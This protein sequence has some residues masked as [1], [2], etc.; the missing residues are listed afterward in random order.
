MKKI[1]FIYGVISGTFIIGSMIIGFIMSDGEGFGSSQILGFSIMIVALSFIFMGIKK[2]RDE[3][4]GGVIK[5]WPAFGLGLAISAVATVM[6]IIGWETYL[7]LTDHQF[8]KDY[9][10][11][12]LEKERLSGVSET[13]LAAFAEKME[14]KKEQYAS[15]FFRVPWTFVEIFPVGAIIALLSGAIL[16][17]PGV[18]PAKIKG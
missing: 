17:K 15:P 5:F 4:L 13:E 3:A 14:L 9:T 2:H 8:I 12:L 7:H 16:R 1:A 6:Y 10:A 11:L 18:L